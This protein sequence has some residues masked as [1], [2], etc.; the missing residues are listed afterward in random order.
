[1]N[2]QTLFISDLHLDDKRPLIVDCFLN[3][4]RHEARQAD[5]LYMLGD[6]FEAWIGDD[7]LTALNQ[8]V[9]AT[10]K[11]LT[12]IGVKVY[13]M[14]GNRD[15]LIGKRFAKATGVQILPDP[16]VIDCYGKRILLMH[17]DLLCTDDVKYQAFRKKAHNR[18]LQWLYLSLP[19][20]WR[21][22]IAD[23]ARAKSKQH[24]G[25]TDLSIQDVNQTEVEHRMHENTVD[26]LI[27]GHT[28]RPATH[29]LIVDNK[30]AQRL[31]L[32]AWHEQGQYI[33]VNTAHNISSHDLAA[34]H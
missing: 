11:E 22:N 27:H 15:F 19:L 21:Q 13:F 2:K 31:V 8:K 14:H 3:F 10:L 24:T 6:I 26:L 1:M 4:L 18:L 17:G 20:K 23:K 29:E 9:I 7:D 30:P 34:K 16:T 28:H 32:A 5:A 12:E 25:K 33:A